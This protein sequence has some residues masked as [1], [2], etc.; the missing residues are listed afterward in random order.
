MSTEPAHARALPRK[1]K[2][3]LNKIKQRL[4]VQGLLQVF[5]TFPAAQSFTFHES[6]WRGHRALK[7]HL[8]Y[9]IQVVD[10]NDPESFAESWAYII[11]ERCK[12][13]LPVMI[14]DEGPEVTGTGGSYPRSASSLLCRAQKL[15]P[16][17]CFLQTE[18][19]ANPRSKLC[20]LVLYYALVNGISD[21]AL[22][23]NLFEDSLIDAIAYIVPRAKYQQ[24]QSE[25][26]DGQD[27]TLSVTSDAAQSNHSDGFQMPGGVVRS[28][29]SS[30]LV[31]SGT[32]LEK[33]TK[34][35]GDE[36]IKLLDLIPPL[37]VTIERHNN[38]GY[39][40]FRL[41]L[42]THA[43]SNVYVYR[44]HGK[45]RT[46][47]RILSHGNDD[48]GGEWQ[49][50]DLSNVQL[51][52]PF[53]C[54]MKIKN[55]LV[56]RGNKIRYLVYYYLMLAENE[57]L[58]DDPNLQVTPSTMIATFVSTC[59]NLADAGYKNVDTDEAQPQS[60]ADEGN[61]V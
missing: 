7:I 14:Q 45:R 33:L 27:D 9:R 46:D 13:E 59:R 54:L 12:T 1:W 24:W 56:T 57:G 20:A 10:A 19:P 17:F 55:D 37:P 35:L 51:L 34:A 49:F 18:S 38:D 2:S 52:E 28:V 3:A 15:F 29:G 61:G 4:M 43:G 40:P 30:V 21:V 22:G 60:Q 16:P 32:A 23:W 8:G 41:H 6:N 36:R 58:I 39:W 26:T 42:G 44:K 47:S 25:Q 11:L 31:R 5:G 50:T 48:N 53:A